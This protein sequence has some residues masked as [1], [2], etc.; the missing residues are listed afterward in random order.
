[1]TQ[2][3]LKVLKKYYGYE[4]FRESQENIINS[5]LDKK[6]TLAIMPTGGG[7]SICY[8]IPALLFDG[9]TIVISPL[10]SLMK[11]QVDSIRD[12]GIKAD[13]I[14]SSLNQS[15]LSSII[16]K[17]E[18][19]SIK[20][21][22]IAPE[23]LESMNFFRLVK[24]MSI[25]Q[26][27][28]D[29][30]HCVSQWGHDFRSSYRYIW[31]FIESLN[32]RPVV[33]AFTATAT[34]EVRSDIIKQIRLRDPAV[35]ISGFDRKNLRINCLKIGDRF[36]YLLNYILE[37]KEQAGIVYAS[38][39]KEVD[40]IYDKLLKNHISVVKYHAGLSD[41]ERKKNQEDFVYDR[42][43]VI[44]ATNAFGMG[45]DKS[46]V[47]YV[48][49]YNIPRNI[50]SYYQEIGRAGRDGENSEC[51]LM[52][53]PQDVITQKYL[54]ETSIQS[55][56]RKLNEYKKLQQMIDFV[57]YNGCLRKYILNYFGEEVEYDECGNCSNC[58]S[59]GEYV[60]KTIDAQKVLSC[61]YR[62]K[63]DFG[64]N[65]IVDVLRGSSQK[66]I[67]QNRFNELST[68]GIM[69]EYSKVELS[70]FINTLIAQGHISLKEGEYPT[71]ILNNESIKILKGQEKVV[72][73]E[74][75]K[76]KKISVN[77]DLFDELRTLRREIASEEEVPP[78]L[79]F[80]DS[81]LKELSS[82]YPCK[83]DQML[84]IS[85]VGE[86]KL[87]KYGK[88]FLDKIKDYVEKNNINVNW[89]FEK[90]SNSFKNESRKSDKL[91]THEITIN[92]IK[93]NMGI[94]EIAKKRH[95]T[96]G[97]ILTHITKYFEEG[98]SESLNVD[99]Q[100][101]FSEEEEKTVLSAVKK[102]G[103]ERLY[104]IKE[105]V[106]QEINYDKIKAVIIKNY[107]LAR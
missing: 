85:G 63:R 39:R 11:D 86:L 31:K 56:D 55:E 45:I 71:V 17:L 24:N 104:P 12:L 97:T 84:D 100:N 23:R 41:N 34:R 13:Y 93:Q 42:A 53:A 54:I 57:H 7:K 81:T 48:I 4:S 21:L 22:Y 67:I 20:I 64:V 28:V 72:L 65:M 3:A 103:I 77:N 107:V 5:I 18:Q 43:D 94:L 9:I 46:N 44:V 25:S 14:N 101:V 36:S 6:D 78:Y 32:K 95:L 58:I 102:V 59:E 50:E 37:N 51:I 10:I 49:H 60:D 27:A 98:K 88:M 52:F 68:Y 15:E 8:Q 76:A 30:A 79:V 33:T 90:E 87:K 16:S 1:M 69:R 2:D 40:S 89:A 105:L 91:R 96:I 92:M 74:K 35:F 26:V 62:M 38:T 61:V 19:N 75:I 70:N 29:E 80:S 83:E 99:F 66:K 73:K 82:R 47:R 106:P